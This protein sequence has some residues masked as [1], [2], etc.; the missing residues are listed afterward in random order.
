MSSTHE[1]PDAIR[2]LPEPAR[3]IAMQALDE[4]RRAGERGLEAVNAAVAT[5][6][7]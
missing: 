5:A 7:Q 2:A 6:M 4:R 3:S 1:M